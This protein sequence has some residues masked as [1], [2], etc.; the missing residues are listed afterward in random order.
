MS[1]VI[2]R[3]TSKDGIKRFI[4]S[5]W[6]FYKDDEYWVPPVISDRM[7]LLDVE[8]NPFFKHSEMQLFLA[9]N[10][11]EIVGRIA[12]I[13]NRN[14]NLTH[15]DKTGFWGFFESINDQEVA[16]KLFDS[17]AEW[18]R[19]K[20]YD[21]M[22]GP[23]NPSMNDEIGM[24]FEGYD[25]SPVILMTYNPPYYNELCSN[26]GMEKAK[27]VYAY[28]LDTPA[29]TTEKITRMQ[30]VIR[31]RYKINFRQVNLKNKEQ[32]KKDVQTMKEVYNA[33]WQ[34]NWGFVKWTDEEFDFIAQDLK[35]TADA[36]LGVILEVNGKVAGFGLALPDLNIVLK[37]NKSGSTLGALWNIMT[38]KKHINLCRIIALGVIPEFQNKGLDVLLYY[39]VGMRGVTNGYYHGEASWILEDNL[40]MNRG[41]TQSM[42]A[43]IY[44]KYRLY[45]KQI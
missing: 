2:N 37:N 29:F 23:E 41:L 27:D 19:P 43:K 40:M 8:R 6:K 3:V 11:G 10:N 15:N 36:R 9:E 22:I 45:G 12:A 35:T 4:K 26:Y 13:I 25:S 5:Q 33:A 21:Y 24:L 28:I 17:A 39:E 14:H 42:N 7:K 32:F 38:K 30:D 1:I 44:K 20:G 34:P 16:N 18:L 31:Q